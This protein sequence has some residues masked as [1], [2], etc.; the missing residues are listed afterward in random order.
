MRHH[1]VAVL[2]KRLRA[3]AA[4]AGESDG[5]ADALLPVGDVAAPVLGPARGE[6]RAPTGQASEVQVSLD[7]D[8]AAHDSSRVT[9]AGG[10]TFER[11]LDNVLLLLGR[12]V[13]VKLRVNMARE[14][15]ATLGALMARLK[16][17]GISGHPKA[18]IYTHPVHEYIGGA[19]FQESVCTRELSDEAEKV[20]GLSHPLKRKADALGYLLKQRK[21]IGRA[22]V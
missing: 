12:G 8:K 18:F 20:G 19:D 10:P 17:K 11:I 4:P 3:A 15:I 13:T 7:G 21:E 22:H 1:H 16:E 9:A 2:L 5:A 14:R 6:T